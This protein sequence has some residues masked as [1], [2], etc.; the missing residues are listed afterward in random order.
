LLLIPIGQREILDDLLA[1]AETGLKAAIESAEE[2]GIY[3]A[4][5]P[6]EDDSE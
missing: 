6:D 3:I 1:F 4:L 5:D 2:L